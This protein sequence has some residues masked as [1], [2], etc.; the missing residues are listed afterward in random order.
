MSVAPP[1]LLSWL[2]VNTIGEP[3]VPFAI[4][5]PAVHDALAAGGRLDDCSCRHRE[6]RS[7]RDR[8]PRTADHGF[9]NQWS[10]KGPGVVA[11]GGISM[12]P[13]EA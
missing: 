5:D 8:Q 2:E 13:Q 9:S 11:A 7:L 3:L 12:K 6:R 1:T 10:W 4:S